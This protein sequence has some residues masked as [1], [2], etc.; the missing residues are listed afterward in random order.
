MG[1][2]LASLAQLNWT[3]DFD[4]EGDLLVIV[5]ATRETGLFAS[6]LFFRLMN[7]PEGVNVHVVFY[8]T[9]FKAFRENEIGFKEDDYHYGSRAYALARR[10][11]SDKI[12]TYTLMEND[13]H[14]MEQLVRTFSNVKNIIYYGLSSSNYQTNFFTTISRIYEKHEGKNVLGVYLNGNQE[15]GLTSHLLGEISDAVGIINR[16]I[17][18]SLQTQLTVSTVMFNTLNK[19]VSGTS[20]GQKTVGVNLETGEIN[21]SNT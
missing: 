18:D 2:S 14:N 6:R 19:W 4:P 7:M 10:V 21:P 5:P 17:D 12:K 1:L 15:Q 20:L 9:D 16:P 3:V 13:T 11:V 8:E